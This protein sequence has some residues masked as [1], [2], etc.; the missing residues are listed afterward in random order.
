MDEAVVE[1]NIHH[2]TDSRLLGDGV[3]VLSRL[4]RR[5]KQRLSACDGR[6]DEGF[7]PAGTHL[8]ILAQNIRGAAALPHEY[9]RYA[10]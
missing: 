6:F 1:T 7:R 10:P 4:L 2:P 8:S 9:Q 5:A 3:R